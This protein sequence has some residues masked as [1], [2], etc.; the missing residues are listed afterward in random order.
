VQKTPRSEVSASLRDLNSGSNRLPWTEVILLVTSASGQRAVIIGPGVVCS[1][2]ANGCSGRGVRKHGIAAKVVSKRLGAG[3]VGRR[4]SGIA[5]PIKVWIG[6]GTKVGGIGSGGA[7]GKRR[8]LTRSRC[9]RA[10]AQRHQAK[11]F[12]RGGASGRDVTNISMS[13]I[14][15]R[16]SVFAAWRAAWLCVACWTARRVTGRGVGACI[17]NT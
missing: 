4:A 17:V 15:I 12:R 2:D 9:A 1:R 8:Q 11:I 5:R 13:S 10:S 3:G 6:G 7:S 16:A 14:N